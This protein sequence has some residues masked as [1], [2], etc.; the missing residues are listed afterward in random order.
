[1]HDSLAL[2]GQSKVCDAEILHVVF[3][4]HTLEAGVF[5]LNESLDVLES[6]AGGGGNVL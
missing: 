2:V 3:E 1:V 4:G 6:L 5:F